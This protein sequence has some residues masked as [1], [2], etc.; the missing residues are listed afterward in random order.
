M[1]VCVFLG[2]AFKQIQVL[3]KTTS[4]LTNRFVSLLGSWFCFS[5]D[6]LL[7]YSRPLRYDFSHFC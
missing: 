7:C 1:C 6:V 4:E 2:G 3:E 5:A